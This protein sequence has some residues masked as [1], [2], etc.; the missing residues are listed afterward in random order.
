MTQIPW[1][2]GKVMTE[3]YCKN[4]SIT[5]KLAMARPEVMVKISKTQFKKGCTP[6]NKNI[7]TGLKPRLG[8]KHTLETKR[9]ISEKMKVN[10]QNSNF[11]K[12]VSE[13]TKQALANPK[14]RKIISERTKEAMFRPEILAKTIPTQFKKGSSPWNKNK[15]NVYSQ[16]RLRQM[17]IERLKRIYPKKDT[18]PELALF[19]I[20][21]DLNVP[22]KKHPT[23][24]DI[25]QPDAFVEP[26]I[27]LFAD[28][29][30]WHCNPLK[31]KVS[32]SPA[33][34]KNLKRDKLANE[35]LTKE[36]YIVL[37]FWE[38]DLLNNPILCK[39]QI[40]TCIS[41]V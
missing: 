25:C 34:I 23:I 37:R 24:Q 33:Q 18:A 35:R 40:S 22:F 14:I 12:Q 31:F 11:R 29:D 17:S 38:D 5:T 20:L 1:N 3:K 15:T 6:W 36:G 7:K 16:E 2:K 30:Y 8:I 13:R 4:V 19:Q 28:G 26:N 27:A 39:T 41:P 21:T 9:K 10:M 32:K